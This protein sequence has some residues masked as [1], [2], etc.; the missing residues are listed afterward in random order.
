MSARVNKQILC[1]KQNRGAITLAHQAR[2]ALLAQVMAVLDSGNY[3]A[4]KHL[5]A[6]LKQR[7]N[8]TSH[9]ILKPDYQLWF[10]P[11]KIGR[12]RGKVFLP[13]CNKTYTQLLT[14]IIAI[15]N[16]SAQT[17]LPFFYNYTLSRSVDEILM[18]AMYHAETDIAVLTRRIAKKSHGQILRGF[19]ISVWNTGKGIPNISNALID[20]PQSSTVPYNIKHTPNV[21]AGKGHGLNYVMSDEVFVESG[22]V[23]AMQVGSAYYQ[24]RVPVPIIGTKVTMINWEQTKT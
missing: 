4:A 8:V 3:E 24:R 13:E 22:D 6:Q 17:K 12:D 18:N 2:R 16:T 19:E 14:S 1:L 7:F 23:I 15:K 11:L 10:K 20:G 21:P 5:A 9:L